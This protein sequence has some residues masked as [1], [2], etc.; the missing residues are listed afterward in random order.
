[1]KEEWRSVV[2]Y[3][4]Y[5]EV[6]N[7]GG[8]R[9]VGRKHWNGH[10]WW[11]RNGIMLK[12]QM[13]D[14]GYYIVSLSRNSIVCPTRVHR[15]VAKVFIE[16][17]CDKPFINHKDGNKVNNHL[18]NLEWCTPLENVRHAIKNKFHD[19]ALSGSKFS[20]DEVKK[21][22]VEYKYSKT[23][24]RKMAKKYN[25]TPT[26]IYNLLNFKTWKNVH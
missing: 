8:V 9:S 16:N 25:V 23:S 19:P 11:Y 2:G 20:R 1:M 12:P 15:L 7:S 26:T 5:Y 6:S 21:I 18:D 4:G 22:R 24:H 17:K 10:A 3:E 13:N 14:K